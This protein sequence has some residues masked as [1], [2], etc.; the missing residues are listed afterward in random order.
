MMEDWYTYGLINTNFEVP[1][2]ILDKTILPGFIYN[3]QV[4]STYKTSWTLNFSAGHTA[5]VIYSAD[6]VWRPILTHLYYSKP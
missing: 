1:N 3:N 5:L 2:S 4:D 6:A